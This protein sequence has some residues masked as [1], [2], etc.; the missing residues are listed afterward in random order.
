MCI[1]FIGGLIF[2]ILLM[3]YYY[4]LILYTILLTTFKCFHD[5][6]PSYLA[7]FCTP[8]TFISLTKNLRSV[9]SGML[10][11]PRART[12]FYGEQSFPAASPRLWNDFPVNLR[13]HS[14]SVDT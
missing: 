6:A 4:R 14:Q 9:E 11:V 2:N 13:V 1:S 7:D 10:A 5:F 3:I 12:V 8:L